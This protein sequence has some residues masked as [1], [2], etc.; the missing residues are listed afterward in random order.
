MAPKRNRSSS[1]RASREVNYA[2]EWVQSISDERALNNL[3]VL[4]ILPD[5]AA[6]GWHPAVGENFLTPHSDELVVFEDY[7]IGGFSVLIHPF[8]HR[9][10]DHYGISLCNLGPNSILH[11]AIF[12]NLCEAYLGILPHFDVFRHVFCLK[13]R[14]LDPR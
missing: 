1:R 10:I 8:L 11:V 3:V 9:L 2:E 13:M 12:I 14:G 4:R 5:R 6:A 7:F